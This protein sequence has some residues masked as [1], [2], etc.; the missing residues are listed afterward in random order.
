MISDDF[1]DFPDIVA[2]DPLR[3]PIDVSRLGQSGH[4][5]RDR[6]IT[7]H[8]VFFEMSTATSIVAVIGALAT[9][10]IDQVMAAL[11]AVAEEAEALRTAGKADTLTAFPPLPKADAA[12]A[13]PRCLL[14][15]ERRHHRTP[16]DW[17]H[18]SRYAC[19]IPTGYSE[20]R[21]G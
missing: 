4:W 5:V 6:F 19:R 11:Q 1:G 16:G 15:R 14:R 9:P 12:H 20:P 21:S 8:G 7:E 2:I 10:D 3:I 13:A 17:S 18:F